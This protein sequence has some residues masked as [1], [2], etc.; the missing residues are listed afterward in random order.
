MKSTKIDGRQPVKNTEPTL[1][2]EATTDQDV[3]ETAVQV[4]LLLVLHL[5][6]FMELSSIQTFLPFLIVVIFGVH[7]NFLSI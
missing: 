1:A 5:L 3:A 2:E 4:R 6:L 7:Y